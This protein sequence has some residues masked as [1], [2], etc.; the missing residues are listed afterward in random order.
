MGS[1]I[2]LSFFMGGWTRKSNEF[3]YCFAGKMFT[4]AK[5]FRI[6]LNLLKIFFVTAECFNFKIV[7]ESNRTNQKQIQC[8]ENF[9]LLNYFGHSTQKK[10]W[11]SILNKYLKKKV[12]FIALSWP[13]IFFG[14]LSFL[15]C[16]SGPSRL[17]PLLRLRGLR[18]PRLN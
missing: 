5:I 7:A 17:F 15:H 2:F 11:K 4:A 14:F 12:L 3:Y 10:F 6:K 18:R 8:L 13:S 1:S 16:L 9:F